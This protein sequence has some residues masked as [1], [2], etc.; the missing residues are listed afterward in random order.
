[1]RYC[2]NCLFPDTK[3]DLAFDANGKCSAC[4]SYD[5]RNKID[6]TKREYELKNIFEKFKN[7]NNWDCIIPVSGGKDST[8]QVIKVLE[9]G[10]KPLCV[11][12]TTCDLSDLGRKNIENIKSFGVD[13]LEF[14]A[15]KKVRKN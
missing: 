8:Y 5:L 9:Y 1:M 7:D 2:N 10:L 11:T 15:N 4:I 3:P 12:S 13:Y 14:S 6:W